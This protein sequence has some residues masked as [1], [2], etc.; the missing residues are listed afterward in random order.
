M[1]MLKKITIG[2]VILLALIFVISL[3][4]PAT[5]NVER[6]VVIDAPKKAVFEQINTIKKWEVWKGPWQDKDPGIKITYS[7][8]ESG[9]GAKLYF[10][11]KHPDTGQ[12]SV[13]ILKSN[14][15]SS[16]KTEISFGDGGGANGN[17]QFKDAAHGTKVIWRLTVNL[18]MNPVKKI[19]GNLMMDRMVGPDFE[20]GLASLKNVCENRSGT[21]QHQ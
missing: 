4:L 2:I 1:N 3:F 14:P 18:G 11:S 12:G 16:L 17:W 19:M 20:K 13:M 10:D 9:Q 8:P 6:S 5:V 15:Y 21:S 7:G